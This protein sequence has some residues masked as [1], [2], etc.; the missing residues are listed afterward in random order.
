MAEFSPRAGRIYQ[1][2]LNVRNDV[3]NCA[4]GVYDVTS[5]AASKERVPFELPAHA[6]KDT[7]KLQTNARPLWINHRYEIQTVPMPR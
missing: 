1:V 6:C 3:R 7:V 4:V 5:G 2:E